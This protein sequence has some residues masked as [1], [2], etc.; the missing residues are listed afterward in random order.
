MTTIE[1]MKS[2]AMLPQREWWMGDETQHILK[3]L[4]NDDCEP[5]TLIVGGAIRN[6]ILNIPVEDI[7]LATKLTPGDVTWR[8]ENAGIKVIPTGI[9]HGTVTAVFKDRS[10]E[11]TTLRKDIATDGRRA[12]TISFSDNWREDAERRDFTMNTLLADANG[13]VYDPLEKGFEDI[14]SRHVV[15]AGVPSKRIEE[16]YLRI[17]RFF[18]FHALY[19]SDEMDGKALAA[20]SA[21]ADK[22][23][24]LSKERISQEFYKICASKRFVSILK[25]M[26]ENNVLSDFFVSETQVE[27][28]QHFC[29]F[30]DRYGLASLASRLFVL[31]DLN[32]DNINKFSEYLVYPKVF[33]KDMDAFDRVLDLPEMDNDQAVRVAVYKYGR[34]AAA[35]ALMMELVQDRVMNGYA[36]TALNII[37]NWDVPN[38]PIGGEDIIRT[39]YKPGPELG[40]ILSDLEDKWIKSGFSES[41]ERLL[42]NL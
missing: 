31:A 16:D 4:N 2:V 40:S 18:R 15:F 9:D 12:T 17:L 1:K 8:L 13:H 22:I 25:I 3:V 35:Q 19:G 33:L 42:S 21:A 5:L 37:Q 30:Q 28:L 32:R 27:N 6:A 36:N 10:Y 11:I 14:K 29:E 7:D 26:F 20:C 34:A 39:G 24:T 23:C 38:F 41:K